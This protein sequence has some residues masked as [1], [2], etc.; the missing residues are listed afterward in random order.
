MKNPSKT[1]PSANLCL[2]ALDTQL[3]IPTAVKSFPENCSTRRQI[4]AQLVAEMSVG[5]T[6]NG[7]RSAKKLKID[8]AWKFGNAFGV[9]LCE[10]GQLAKK[11]LRA[12][13]D[14]FN[15]CYVDI[16]E[17]RMRKTLFIN[18][19]ETFQQKRSMDG[20]FA[21]ASFNDENG[22]CQPCIFTPEHLY[23]QLI[24]TKTGQ[25][26]LQAECAVDDVVKTLQNF[27]LSTNVDQKR[28]KASLLALAHL[29]ANV[30]PYRTQFFVAKTS[31]EAFCG[32]IASLVQL[33]CQCVEQ[34]Q[35]LCVRG[36]A[37]WAMNIAANGNGRVAGLLTAS[38]WEC[39]QFVGKCIETLTSSALNCSKMS[40]WDGRDDNASTASDQSPIFSGRKPFYARKCQKLDDNDDLEHRPRICTEFPRRIVQKSRNINRILRSASLTSHLTSFGESFASVKKEFGLV[41]IISNLISTQRLSNI[42]EKGNSTENEHNHRF[43]SEKEN[44]ALIAYRKFLVTAGEINE[45]DVSKRN[46]GLYTPTEDGQQKGIFLP[47]LFNIF[48]RISLERTN[49][50]KMFEQ[51]QNITR[52]NKW[53]CIFC[54]NKQYQIW[55]GNCKEIAYA[56]QSFEVI[57]LIDR[58]A[59]N[60]IGTAN[61][62]NQ[63]AKLLRLFRDG[64]TAVFQD[65][66]LISDVLQ[67]ISNSKTTSLD[68][69]CT[70]YELFAFA[71]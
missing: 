14:H 3:G 70:I 39:G 6:Q 19:G 69:R 41:P 54:A 64:P 46:I 24:R 58:L 27:L 38:G 16:V 49:D 68:V 56:G 13:K 53:R 71:F 33:L 26:L 67:L 23:G 50:N 40:K 10:N 31:S 63:I 66:C 48:G 20:H 47:T 36:F 21:R 34:Q 15:L 4:L 60:E 45:Y 43:I 2:L 5:G 30:D 32:S 65:Q 9:S 55:P 42:A 37:L 52:H 35:S 62:N 29:L 17:E 59:N 12:W 22:K 8:S 18:N 44:S 51:R 25:A 61:S 11:A 7:D 28:V 57:S 1:W